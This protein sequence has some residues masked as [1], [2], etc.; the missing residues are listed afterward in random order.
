MIQVRFS[1][2][3]GAAIPADPRAFVV[4]LQTG[5][6][7]RATAVAAAMLR[8]A[9]PLGKQWQGVA[10]FAA[11]EGEWPI[12]LA[13]MTRF[14]ADDPADT[15]RAIAL[16]ELQTDAGRV[17]AAI[18]TLTAALPR[19]PDDAGLRHFLGVALIEVGR[20]DEGLEH[21]RAALSLRPTSGASWLALANASRFAGGDPGFDALQRAG[22]AMRHAAPADRA[23]WSYALG[24]ALDDLGEHDRAF[25]A[26]ADGA[27]IVAATRRY[28]A[29][30]DRREALASIDA[31]RRLLDAGRIPAAQPPAGRAIFVTGK[32]R[33][34]TTLVD[35]TL[36]SHSTVTGGGEINLMPLA[37]LQAT[38]GARSG[39]TVRARY[40]HLLAAR[41][42]KAGRIVDK[43]LNTSRIAA[44]LRM[45]LPEAP[46][47]WL[48]RDPLDTAWSSFRTYFARGVEWSFDLVAMAQ[49]HA[50]EDRL[51]AFWA[52]AYGP[53]L[54]VLRYADLVDDPA[55]M[56]DRIQRHA[57]LAPEEQVQQF[58]T[59]TRAVQT[60]SVAQVRQPINRS[61]MGTAAPYRAHLAPYER[62]YA[63]ARRALGLS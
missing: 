3:L 63:E 2:P 5:D 25:A 43:S 53:R 10:R 39:A 27:R 22:D 16:A 12:A 9:T 36:E 17:A 4:A 15:T 24:K 29:A 48:D 20:R 8:A 37:V 28:D 59:H 19:A 58:H 47:L 26:F 6:P 11:T 18:D 38:N 52:D 35:Q 60:A 50:I 61:G 33:S 41:F 31:A 7:A 42:G 57:G 30:A 1:P 13:A 44:Q 34:G 49:Y 55:G 32:P 54:L 40:D 51:R 56:I 46:V 23:G 62:A 14:A 21:L 45:A